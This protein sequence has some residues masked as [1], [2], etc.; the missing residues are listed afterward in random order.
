MIVPLV[1]LFARNSTSFQSTE[2]S[3]VA[4]RRHQ[5][6]RLFASSDDK[7]DPTKAMFAQLADGLQTVLTSNSPLNE[8]KKAL[9]R[10]LAGDYDVDATKAKLDNLIADNSILMLSFVKWP[11]CIKA[12]DILNSKIGKDKYTVVELDVVPDGKALRAELAN[13]VGRT[14]VPA[15]WIK[16]QF[17]GGCNDGPMGGIVSLNESGQLD[18]L[19]K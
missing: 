18:G 12:K 2:R 7:N 17:I 5:H 13:L 9:V 16:G 14:S 1:L 8:G 6:Q 10:A 11:F 4:F 15:I 3:C 19:L